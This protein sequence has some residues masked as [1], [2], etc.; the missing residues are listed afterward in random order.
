MAT[1]PQ[2]RNPYVGPRPFEPQDGDRFF[3]RD[4]EAS[5]LLSLVIAHRVL[6]L[7]AQSGAGKTSLINALLVSL[8][9]EEGFE[10]L[11]LA[12]VRGLIPHDIKPREVPNVYV[13]NTLISWAE[14]EA[15]P[16]RLAHTSLAD[17]LSER[18]RPSDEEG[19]PAPRVLIFDQFEELFAFYPERWEDREGFFGQVRDALEADPLLRVVFVVRGI[20]QAKRTVVVLSEAYLADYMAD[21]ENVLAQT[22]GIQEG[23]YRLLPVKIEAIDEDQLPVRLGML[24]TLNL[25]HPRRAQREFGRLVQALQG[26]L[27]RR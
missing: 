13:F 12:R 22:M 7:Y 24:T 4:R 27:S 10:V 11:P 15:D 14:D 9:Q 19:L 18:V 6:L 16:G 17:F 3:G 20:K 8:L 26:A 25:I 5:E 23:S 2:A 21:F 1:E